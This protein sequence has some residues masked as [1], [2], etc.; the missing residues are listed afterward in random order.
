MGTRH[1]RRSCRHPD[2]KRRAMCAAPLPSLLSHVPR[3]RAALPRAS[4]SRRGLPGLGRAP[5]GWDGAAPALLCASSILP[6]RA[7]LHAGRH[8]ALRDRPL[9]GARR[10]PPIRLTVGTRSGSFLI[11]HMPASGA[12]RV[13]TPCRNGSQQLCCVLPG[14]CKS[15]LPTPAASRSNRAHRA[16]AIEFS[17][18]LVWGLCCQGS[19]RRCV[20]RV[21]GPIG[22][23][24]GEPAP[25]RHARRDLVSGWAHAGPGP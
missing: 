16:R 20:L 21:V 2:Q 4:S 14:C 25:G 13:K 15:A 17:H 18:S 19:L 5:G 11:R 9:P 23:T 1:R 10:R 22:M 3:T 7:S 6:R 8:A 24:R 12:D